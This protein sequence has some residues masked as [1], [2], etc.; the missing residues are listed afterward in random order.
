MSADM[1][2]AL[3]QLSVCVCCCGDGWPDDSPGMQSSSAIPGQRW[4]PSQSGVRRRAVWR[5]VTCM[6]GL[7]RQSDDGAVQNVST[8]SVRFS[9][10]F[11]QLKLQSSLLQLMSELMCG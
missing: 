3:T 5:T 9:L 6:L 1:W 2:G 4:T 11:R 7:V 8:I 10:A